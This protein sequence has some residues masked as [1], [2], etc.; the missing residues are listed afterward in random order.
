MKDAETSRGETLGGPT[1]ANGAA[2][3]RQH[4]APSSPCPRT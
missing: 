3:Q 1:A 4:L 2:L